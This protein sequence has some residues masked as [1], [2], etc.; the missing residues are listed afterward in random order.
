VQFGYG[1]TLMLTK[2]I[3]GKNLSTSFSSA[4]DAFA[5][6]VKPRVVM[7][8]LDSRHVDNLTVTTNDPHVNTA[9]G[10]YA[11]QMAG[12]TCGVGYFFDPKQ[13]MN[14]F[15]RQAFTWAVSDEKDVNGK[16]I[17]ADGTWH[18]M[19]TELDD[20]YEFGWRSNTISTTT[21][22][23]NGGFEFTEPITLQYDFTERKVSKIRITT[24]DFYGAISSYR[25][26]V[27]NDALSGFYNTH[28]T[29]EEGE[30]F[31]EHIL[32]SNIS[33]DVDK[34]ILTIY[35]TQNP[36]DYARV[37]EV[38]PI[39]EVDVTDFVISHSVDR[40]GEL[41]ENSIPIAGTGS[42][43]AAITLDN[44]RGDFNPFD[45]SS[46]YGKYMKK[47][48]KVNIAN[49]W[50]VFKTEN[51][52]VTTQL[53]SNINSTANS[54]T[55]S[56]ASNFLNGNA[57]N[58]F[59]L[60]IEPNTANE[61]RVL[62]ST[63]TDV[64]V[65]IIQRGYAGTKAISHS[66]GSTV[67]FDPY[68]YVNAGE[69]FVDEWS[70][71]T[72]MTVAVKCI[73]K[74]K[75]LTEKQI[76]KG[77]YVQNSTVGDAVEKMLMSVN[78]SKNEF[79][80]IKPYT[81]FAKENAIALYNFSTPIERNEQAL[82]Q[83]DGFRYRIWK[84]EP[85]RENEV[86]DI[87]ADALDV[88]L[89]D[90]DKAMGAKPYIP[91]TYIA[92]ST[93]E[94]DIP[95]GI[96]A[97]GNISVAVGM[98]DFYFITNGVNQSEYFNG[99]IDGYYIAQESGNQF[100][101]I[102][103]QSGGFRM[104]LDDNLIINSW[105]NG[106]PSLTSRSVSSYDY[107]G[108]YLDLDAGT[109][110][111]VRIEFYHR[112]GLLGSG[113]AFS[114][115]LKNKLQS[116]EL[117]PLTIAVENVR[118]MVAEDIVGSRDAPFTKGAKNANHHKNNGIYFGDVNLDQPTG[119]VSEP[120]GKSVE[121][122]SV[123]NDGYVNIPYHQSLDL[124]SNASINY[125][126]E[127][128]YEIYV[129]FPNSPF[130][131]SGVYISN[132]TT[133]S[134]VDYGF[135]FFNNSSSHGFTMYTP[136]GPKTVSSNTA[137][138]TT[139]WHHICVTYKNS[140]LKYYH[141]GMQKDNKTHAAGTTFGLGDMKIGDAGESFLIDEFAI[142][143]KYLDG[144]TVKN[145]YIATQIK[146]LT[147]FPH[148][149]GND[150]SAKSIIDSITLADFGR[151]YVD[152]D[153]FFRYI[154]FFRYFEPTIEQH[155][156]VQKTISSNSHIISG[157][158][159]VQ[160]Q[161]NKVTVNVTEYNPL[162]SQRQGLWTAT[163]DPSTLGVVRLTSNVNSTANTIPVSTTDNPPFP[164]SGY[165]KIDQEIMKYTSINSTNFLGVTRGEFETTPASHFTNDLVR[166][167]RY[168]D[169]KYDN[170]PA[171]NVQRPLITSISNTFP[172]TIELVKF[173][174]NAYNA[175][176]IL[177]ASTSVPEGE[178]AFIQGTNPRTGDVNYTAIAGVPVV[179]Q[180]SSNL[181]KK[182]TASFSE[183]IRKYG[184][185]EVVIENSYIYS[186]DK[187]QQIADFLIDKFKEPVPVL[188]IKTM[189]IPNI[190]I[191]DRIRI[192]ELTS[193]NI[194]NTDYWVVSHSLSVGDSLDHSLTLRKVI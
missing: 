139:D 148:L 73:D 21:P 30:Y 65:A 120:S 145:R 84:I 167:T 18:C 124:K 96:T 28:S 38:S 53:S 19:P 59:T 58:T 134:S 192:S 7:T 77:F 111:K 29:I 31:K 178:L 79:L 118:T 127:F 74:S 98:S 140:V 75:L 24:S 165:L 67:V 72:E 188:Q 32:P 103:C 170:V 130:S 138:N 119:I 112:E 91:P 135:E 101:E 87:K 161:T 71:G 191:G 117:D 132:K 3:Y 129:K 144:D 104:Y 174:S 8:F 177:A 57:T 26:D 17:K 41:W 158:Y 162:I 97:M 183:D 125:T 193:L 128:S 49:G 151:F 83:L 68:E 159:N 141:N 82:S 102:Q 187:A 189:A 55:V 172:A 33:S 37:H 44:T 50:R 136:D 93:T 48:V 163:P 116:S 64:T 39:Y 80:Q 181:V 131:G 123:T 36:E 70:G 15:E 4:I 171:F 147:V 105:S 121:F 63:R 155:S 20:E 106:E 23:A 110:Y 46:T 180:E 14:G 78:I 40:Q 194:E 86:K 85:G 99:V 152:E 56:D 175:E 126:G 47:D 25:I 182:Q 186:A 176:L 109:P 168:Y 133:V 6:K 13:S 100:F 137:L 114:L 95:N 69:F 34:I 43:S 81:Q 92:Y 122:L 113:Y 108:Q 154:H 51:V 146:E 61:E 10:T 5:Q 185:K 62:C 66:A 179:K 54:I 156:T 52:L 173:S 60:V 27:F 1:G 164:R 76:T 88:T 169:I 190:Q 149:Y 45:P 153:D 35:S 150:Q 12:I 89:T 107:M 142:Y 22:H 94:N 143:N 2:D 184:L 157:E 90:Y 42:S 9:K 160:L 11:Q 16:V 115:F 166:E